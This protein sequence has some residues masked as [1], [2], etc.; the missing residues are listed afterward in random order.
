MVRGLNK[1]PAEVKDVG[2]AVKRNS[3]VTP[4][5]CLI[6]SEVPIM[7]GLLCTVHFTARKTLIGISL[8]C[9]V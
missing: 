3:A 2:E 9:V 7:N 1:D 4:L 6:L 8:F 5:D